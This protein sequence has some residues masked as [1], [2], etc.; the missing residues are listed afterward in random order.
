MVVGAGLLTSLS[1]QS[2]LAEL[3]GYQLLIGI[4][5]G[6]AFQQPFVAL[7]TI[8][9]PPDIPRGM[10]LI[11]FAQ[12]LGS[13]LSLSV[14]NNIFSNRL[15]RAHEAIEDATD[16]SHANNTTADMALLYPNAS[17]PEGVLML[18]KALAPIFY[19]SLVAALL[20]I[21]IG[22]FGIP[23]NSV[24]SDSGDMEVELHTVADEVTRAS[25][26]A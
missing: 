25:G 13:T 9:Q 15:Q 11:A 17:G 7:Q 16:P 6:M 8:L 2:S 12:T 23:W 26:R 20:M 18:G 1:L 21:V 19:I 5:G 4:G 24:K 3:I 10:A 22:I 14:A